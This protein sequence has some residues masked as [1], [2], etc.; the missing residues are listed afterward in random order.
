MK[1]LIINTLLVFFISFLL[2]LGWEHLH[3]F[4]YKDFPSHVND[5]PILVWASIVDADFITILYLGIALINRKAKWFDHRDVGDYALVISVSM[6]TA[7]AIEKNALTESKWAYNEL[8]PIVPMFEVGL[9]PF[10]QL[11]V[12]SLITFK[13][14]RVLNRIA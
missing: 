11:A 5:M 1:A 12:L 3:V 13:I 4:L 7:V 14:V 10:L 8:M 2:N 9:T 6:I